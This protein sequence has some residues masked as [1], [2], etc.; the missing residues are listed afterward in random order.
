MPDSQSLDD[1]LVPVHV[2]SKEVV[3]KAAALQQGGAKRAKKKGWMIDEGVVA[4]IATNSRT[5]TI[6]TLLTRATRPRR[7][8]KSLGLDWR[9]EVR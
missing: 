7:V 8:E 3:E 9:C 4:A 1:L 2:L 5:S 6:L